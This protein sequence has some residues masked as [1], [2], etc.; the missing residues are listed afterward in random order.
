[1]ITIALDEQGKFEEAKTSRDPIFIAGILYDD[2]GN[3]N[4]A[5][6]ER[7]RL[8]S[9]Y[10]K[11]CESAG[12]TYPVDLHYEDDGNG[13]NNNDRVALTKQQVG[14]TLADFLKKGTYEGEKVSVYF[15]G[16][17]V[18]RKGQYHIFA[19]LRSKAGKSDMVKKN[20]SMLVD[21]QVAGNLYIHMAEEVVSRL[22]FHNPLFGN[23]KH[24]RLDLATRRG[25]IEKGNIEEKFQ[26]Y[27]R[28]GYKEDEKHSTKE[29]RTVLLT[30]ADIYRTALEREML[31]REKSEIQVECVGAKS[32]YYGESSPR[33]AFLY[34]SDS[35][36]SILGYELEGKKPEEWIEEFEKRAADLTGAG[37][38]IIFAYDNIDTYFRKAWIKVEEADYFEALSLAYDG[39]QLKSEMKEYYK[40]VW[41]PLLQKK[42]RQEVKTTGYILA[43]KKLRPMILKNGLNQEKLIFIFTELEKLVTVLEEKYN[44]EI[45]YELYDVGVTAF[46]HIGNSDKAK[47]YFEKCTAYAAYVGAEVYL[48]TCNKMVV[49]MCDYFK[50]EEALQ[51]ATDNV[52]YMEEIQNLRSMMFPETKYFMGLA[53]AYSQ[54]GQVYAYMRDE[55]AEEYFMKA[56]DCL[57]KGS[58]NYNI[59]LSYLLHYYIEIEDE[60]KYAQWVKEYF[61][62]EAGLEKQFHYLVMEGAKEDDAKISLKFALFLFIKAV[63]T[64]YMDKAGKKLVNKLLDVENVMKGMTKNIEKQLNGH[65]W[66]IIYK[67]CAFIALDTGKKDVAEVFINKSQECLE[68]KGHTVD[69]LVRFGVCQYQEKC[70][71]EPE[72]ED[73]AELKEKITYMYR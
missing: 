19:L 9:Y 58:P 69:E 38:N 63:Y 27:A 54:L 56:L 43:L 26:E 62:G 64:F 6:N 72:A 65:P 46:T 22:V 28:L 18:E 24:V 39:L 17:E 47:A 68:E 12:T 8:E 40:K 66:E 42:L 50:Y 44:Q 11:V 3:V 2:K 57:E 29:K 71:M 31:E 37:K 35:V 33:M 60:A 16:K 7:M 61:G 10:A 14:K 55:M 36:C 49:F 53:K 20:V 51:M 1:M 32:I 25:V 48:A 4:D 41:L 67:Y 13:G 21:E 70:G 34:L 15:N 5:K 52:V 23:M 59:T 73:F 30:N 45:F